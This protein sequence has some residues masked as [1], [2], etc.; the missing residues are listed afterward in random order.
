[1]LR[2]VAVPEKLYTVRAN[3]RM[4][5]VNVLLA[6]SFVPLS[7]GTESMCVLLRQRNEKGQKRVHLLISR[8]IS[9]IFLSLVMEHCIA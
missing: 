5:E 3:F 7:Q 8:D 2:F 6:L 1:M 9:Y 4:A